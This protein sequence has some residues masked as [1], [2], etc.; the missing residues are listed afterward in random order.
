MEKEFTI[1]ED[2]F[3]SVVMPSI[4]STIVSSFKQEH[5]AMFNLMFALDI[6]L[7]KGS[8]TEHDKDFF[9]QNLI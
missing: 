1:D 4:H 3:H 5:M 6:A 9:L 8:I 7:R 2:F